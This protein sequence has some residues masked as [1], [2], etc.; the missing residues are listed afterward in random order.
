MQS[1][2]Q[3]VKEKKCSYKYKRRACFI[4]NILN[5]NRVKPARKGFLEIYR[6]RI[7]SM[8]RIPLNIFIFPTV[9]VTRI[10]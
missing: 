7:I 5:K 3:K 2:L 9:N 6:I 4:I 1:V 10:I 8:K